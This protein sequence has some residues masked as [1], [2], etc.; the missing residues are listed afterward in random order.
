MGWPIGLSGGILKRML[1]SE[2]PAILE[3]GGSQVLDSVLKEAKKSARQY[4]LS[5]KESKA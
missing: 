5:L 2:R 3:I 1:Q 4:E